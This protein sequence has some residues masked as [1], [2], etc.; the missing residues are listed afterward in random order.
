MKSVRMIHQA[1][2]CALLFLGS[3]IALAS[4]ALDHASVKLK[5]AGAATPIHV[6]AVALPYHWDRLHGEVDGQAHF[7]FAFSSSKP[8]APQAIFIPR[9]G[10]TFNITL[11]GVVIGKMGEAGNKFEDFSKQPHFFAIPSGLLQEHNKLDVTIDVQAGRKGGLSAIMLGDSDEVNAAYLSRY[12]WQVTG[13]LVVAVVSAVLGWMALI[14]WIRQ[15]E[16]MYLFYALSELLW[17]VHV[18]DTF[19]DYSP[20]P[21]PW[22]GVLYFTAYAVSAVLAFKFALLVMG[23]H[24]G[25]LKVAS[26]W[27]LLLITPVAL[28]GLFAGLPWLEQVL[29][30]VTDTICLGII[31]TVVRQGIRSQDLGQRV[32]ALGMLVI[33]FAGIRDD[34]VLVLLPYTGLLPGYENYF[35]MVPWTRYAWCIFGISMAWIIAERLRKS[36]QDIEGMNQMLLER[37]AEREAE[38]NMVFELQKKSGWQQATMEE[39]QRLTR[40]MHDGLGSQLLAALHLA[41]DPGVTRDALAQ[42]LRET[43]DHL[44]LT[45]DAM[46]DTEGD[47]ASLLGALRYRLGPRLAAAGVQLAWSVETLPSITGWTLHQS[48]DLQMI[49]FEA[50]SNL[51]AHANATQA[52][53]HALPHAGGRHI[54]IMLKDNGHGFDALTAGAA[55]VRRGRG[56]SNMH[57]RAARIN[58]QLQIESTSKGTVTTLTL[59]LDEAVA[60]H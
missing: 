49:L 43:M 48:R 12:R 22:W 8:T 17:V 16:R 39:R 59:P 29:K 60:S 1:W 40:D 3:S 25:V 10:N 51:I 23:L 31:V 35:E 26:D 44:K 19:I 56:T 45:V 57:T 42:Q 46:Q 4:T 11:N 15:R 33:F 55:G 30:I 27:N 2:F 5:L 24:K 32:L 41:Q 58:A 28:I 47:V 50:F 9:I 36:A 52:V 54:L 13:A 38:L 21:W 6:A 37:L 53:L 14:L 20:L 34:V 18:S 7:S